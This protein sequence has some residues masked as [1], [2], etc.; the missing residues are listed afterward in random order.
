MNAAIAISGRAGAFRVEGSRLYLDGGDI[1]NKLRNIEGFTAGAADQGGDTEHDTPAIRYFS[2][3]NHLHERLWLAEIPVLTGAAAQ[4]C[5][6]EEDW[7]ALDALTML[8]QLAEEGFAKPVE[9]VF[10][11]AAP[12]ASEPGMD[13]C[14]AAAKSAGLDEPD[15]WTR[16]AWLNL[17]DHAHRAHI[18]MKAGQRAEGRVELVIEPGEGIVWR[19]DRLIVE[20]APGGQSD[21]VQIKL[22]LLAG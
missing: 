8:L 22:L 15:A 21:S 13:I 12:P 19:R 4:G 5:G 7:K 16:C 14:A 6:G 1:A 20:E 3:P 2:I 18:G 10:Q 17:D 9:A 11:A